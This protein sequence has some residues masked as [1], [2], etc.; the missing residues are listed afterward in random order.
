MMF[1]CQLP[2]I[3]ECVDL[4]FIFVFV[5]FLKN[6]FLRRKDF[7]LVE[8]WDNSADPQVYSNSIQICVII[9]KSYL[10]NHA[11]RL[12]VEAERNYLQQ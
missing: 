8:D 10:Q 11:F 5:V 1:W 9:T 4:G 2:R 6:L 3:I 7:Q 12:A